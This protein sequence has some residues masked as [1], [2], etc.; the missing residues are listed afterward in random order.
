MRRERLYQTADGWLC[1][2]AVE[3]HELAALA[4]VIGAELATAT[5]DVRADRISAAFAARKTD[6]LLADLRAAGVPAAEP[7]GR[8]SHAFMNDP[9]NRRTGRVAEVPHP[10]LGNVREL[11]VLL[12][13]SD[14]EVPAHRLAPDLGEHTDEILREVGYADAQVEGLRAGRDPVTGL[15]DG[16]RVV[17][18]GVLLTVDFLGMLL[19]DEGADV[20]KV[21]S[22]QVGDYIRNI[23]TRFA[24]DW[25]TFHL[26]V[27]RN[28]R[29]VTIDARGS[30]GQAVLARLL[31]TADVFITGNVG[32]T[33]DK[34]GLD[35]ETVRQIKPD[36]VY[37]Q[38]TGFG[39]AGPYAEIPTHGQ[40]M[41]ALGGGAPSLEVGDDGF[42]H[43]KQGTEAP[44]SSG[45]VVIGPLYAAFGVA[46]GLSRRD[47]TGEGCYLDVSCA[48]AVIAGTWLRAVPLLNPEKV[49][50]DFVGGGVQD[51]AKYQ[52]Y[53]T[54]DG[55]FVLFCGIEAKFWDHFCRAVGREDLL[56]LHERD[57][58]VDFAND[59]DDLRRELTTI[60]RSKTQAEWV[61]I[62]IAA[63]VAMGPALRFD[64]ITDD[65]HVRARGMVVTDEH[66][67][68]GPF[69][70]YG[71]PL[72]RAGR[73]V[74][75]PTCAVA[76]RAHRRGPRGARLL[77]RR[78]H[79]LARPRCGVTRFSSPCRK[80]GSPTRCGPRSVGSTATGCRCRSRCPT[81][82]SGRRPC[83]TPRRRRASTGTRSTPRPLR[84][85]GS[86]RPRS[87]TRSRG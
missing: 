15:L 64:E 84:P 2:V 43:V 38:A 33:N 61:A 79:R 10:A 42:T 69:L 60:F 27:N 72:A 34:L 48:D 44:G 11:A 3:D 70:T 36:I 40:M 46:A 62:A 86:S 49:D 53:E 23:L 13:V 14:T 31:E 25:S 4:R 7:V 59:G 83:T 76:R 1:V 26:S 47:R 17:E 9:E 63:D 30:E 52:Y 45:G 21:E 41:D 55:K 81:S 71:N 24:P 22:P 50:A 73:A 54:S 67:V 20:V 80:H 32:S 39:A 66:P 58:V 37:C 6:E 75:D 57:R 16:V 87:S 51:S 29:S 82:E 18:T 68:V 28:K 78:A 12:R 5:D 85:A 56:A 8:N 35:Y 65:P 77:R 74:L 19:G